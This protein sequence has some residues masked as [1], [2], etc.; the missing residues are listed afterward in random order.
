MKLP[1][2]RCV[3]KK[4]LSKLFLSND[5]QE[6]KLFYLKTV[7]IALTV[8]FY[9]RK[10][11]A[12]FNVKANINS[13]KLSNNVYWF[14]GHRWRVRTCNNRL[15]IARLLLSAAFRVP[16]NCFYCIA[17]FLL[18]ICRFMVSNYY[19]ALSDL[20]LAQ[21]TNGEKVFLAEPFTPLQRF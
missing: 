7:Q 5:K 21:S 18:P 16:I 8:L 11:K 17:L 19:L 9:R 13:E 15:F 3:W 10:C 6:R 14:P 12:R 20:W 4:I 1:L 2:L